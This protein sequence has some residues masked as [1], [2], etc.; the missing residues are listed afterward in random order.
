MVQ[1]QAEFATTKQQ[2]AVVAQQHDALQQA[3]LV[4]RAE[5]DTLFRTRQEEIR[6]SEQ[7]LEK[8]LFSQKFD[9]LDLKNMQPDKFRGRRV[10]AFKPWAR[11]LK[12]YCN[13]KRGGFRKALEWAEKQSTKIVDLTHCPWAEAQLADAK[14]HDFL[15]MT[16]EEDAQVLVE[17]PELE[18]RGFE[19][20]RLL[21]LRYDPQG[22]QYELDAMMALMNL[23]AVKD[24]TALPGAISR[25]ERDM[26]LYESRSG[27]AFPEEFKVPT[28]LKL[29]PKTH[30]RELKLKFAMGLTNYNEL[31]AQIMGYS[32][33]L[34]FE[35]AYARGDNDSAAMDVSSLEDWRDWMRVASPED[36]AAFYEGVQAGMNGEVPPP[37]SHHDQPLDEISRK[38][39][40]K[41]KGKKG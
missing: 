20:W 41:G 1:L 36:V 22:G 34:R 30:E 35:G 17:T 9:L 40:S 25:F 13:A 7:K 5:S 11:K 24:I 6:A 29:L 10:E 31:T 37:P 14:L 26:K 39:K 32:Q 4:L 2:L 28:F 15:L 27:R 23:T 38:G 3:H 16:L 19:A 21:C 33:Q 12:A 18:C 8:L